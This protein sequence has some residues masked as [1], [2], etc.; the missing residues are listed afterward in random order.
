MNFKKDEMK[1]ISFKRILK[2]LK[3]DLIGKDSHRGVT[4][5]CS[6]LANQFGHFSLGFIPSFLVF[7]F[8]KENAL[9]SSCIVS[10]FWTAFELYNFLGPLV[11]NRNKYVFNPKWLNV[12]FDTFTDLCFFWLGAF[13]F[14]LLVD[15]RPLTLSIE[16]LLI[17]ITIYSSKYWFLTKMYQFYACYPFQFRLSQWAFQITD[18][19]KERVA[20]FMN[21]ESNS[22]H[23]FIF[24]PQKSGK[25]S[26]GI[27]IVN[28]LSIQHQTC[29]Y[30]SATKL[31]S[32]FYEEEPSSENSYTIWSWREANF[33]VIDD[34]NAGGYIEDLVS[35]KQFLKYIDA[36][37]EIN[38]A[39]IKNKNIIW[40][41]G[42][43]NTKEFSFQNSWVAMLK[44][45]GVDS[46][47]ITSLNLI[48]NKK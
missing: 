36:N 38:R 30:T 39:L 35:P 18:N 21:S 25:T 27:G 47:K 10:I 32:S 37:L 3:A 9:W 12:A 4:L 46:K 34:I 45:I 40:I 14:S 33:L 17:A 28:E 1:Y 41:L 15:Y 13:S 42:N 23:L 2:Q 5:T 7:Y 11:G 48:K 6:W 26:L 31:F 20:N 19:D 44:E 22:N 24:G 16:L 43:E 8:I 29:L